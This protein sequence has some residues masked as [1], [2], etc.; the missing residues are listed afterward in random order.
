MVIFVV[1]VGD[2]MTFDLSTHASW[3]MNWILL[4]IPHMKCVLLCRLLMLSYACNVYAIDGQFHAFRWNVNKFRASVDEKKMC[5]LNKSI[6]IP[7]RLTIVILL[8]RF[9]STHKQQNTSLIKYSPIHYWEKRDIKSIQVS[10][11]QLSL[12]MWNKSF[13]SSFIRS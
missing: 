1:V 3:F 4:N 10:V 6:T 8:L 13:D 9:K 12:S 7:H 2:L 5:K 11:Q